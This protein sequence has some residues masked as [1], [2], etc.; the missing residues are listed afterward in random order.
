MKNM[1]DIVLTL[2]II[3]MT[4]MISNLYIRVKKLEEK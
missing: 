4:F 2:I 1:E 3:T